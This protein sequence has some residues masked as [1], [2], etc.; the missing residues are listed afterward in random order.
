MSALGPVAAIAAS[1][2]AAAETRLNVAAQNVANADSRGAVSGAPAPY[3][4]LR[5]DL[6]SMS[7]GGVMASVSAQQSA[8]EL[9]YDPT[10][11]FA[12]AQGMV[13]SPAVDMALQLINM[14]I[15]MR[16]FQAS[17]QV[18]R[19]ADATSKTLLDIKA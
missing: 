14:R 19:A 17:V 5:A 6:T 11:P 7:A 2:M 4:P 13:A 10:A 1:G 15:A 12:D 8:S 16:Q 3:R 18:F 9:A